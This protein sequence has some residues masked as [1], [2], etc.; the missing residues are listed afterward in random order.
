MSAAIEMHLQGMIDDS[1][2]SADYLDVA[3]P[4]SAA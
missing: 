1:E 4:H 2:P 3:I